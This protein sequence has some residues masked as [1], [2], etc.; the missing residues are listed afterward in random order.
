[1]VVSPVKTN[2]LHDCIKFKPFFIWLG[3]EPYLPPQDNLI[4]T[5]LAE[6]TLCVCAAEDMAGL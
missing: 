6:N 1:M 5:E 2:T 3:S 4:T